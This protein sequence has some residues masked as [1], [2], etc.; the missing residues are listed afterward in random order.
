M[1]ASRTGHPENASV[2][3]NYMIRR[4]WP[5]DAAA[6]STLLCASYFQLMAT[7]YDPA[8]LRDK[9][10]LITRANLPLLHSGRYYVATAED[11]L[12]VGCGGWS[13]APPGARDESPALGHLRHFATHPEWVGRGI[14]RALYDDAAAQAREA[15][16]TRLA[17]YASLNAEAFYAAL[18][19]RRVRSVDVPLAHGVA[20]PA[21]LMERELAMP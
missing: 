4:A 13:K 19:F 16:V 6:V 10:P 8:F 15:G 21:I 11:G 7:V 3:E 17:C 18:G 5:G 14:G 2:N 1:G 9:L 20:F 12:L